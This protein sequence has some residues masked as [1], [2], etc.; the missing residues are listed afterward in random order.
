M[1]NGYKDSQG[2]EIPR[3]AARRV[4][5]NQSLQQA[6]EYSDVVDGWMDAARKDP[7][8]F[9]ELGRNANIIIEETARAHFVEGEHEL[10]NDWR[11]RIQK[12]DPKK[13]LANYMSRARS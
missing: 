9:N 12:T 5:P 4:G 11:D 3:N 10:P 2:A 6:R 13:A 1:S 7:E 8:F